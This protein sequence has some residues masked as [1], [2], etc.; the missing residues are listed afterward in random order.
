MLNQKITTQQFKYDP[1]NKKIMER[2]FH[3]L[4]FESLAT[5]I[6]APLFAYLMNKSII[7]MGILTIAIAT[8]AMSWNFIYNILFDKAQNKYQFSKTP[9][10]RVLHSLLFEF[11]L[12][13]ITIPLAAWWLSISLIS[14][15]FM[16]IGI[17]LFFLPYTIIYNWVYDT[18]RKF[19]WIY[20]Q[21]NRKSN[22]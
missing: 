18:F 21:K 6:C 14:A 8:I 12:I 15:F 17:L 5:L 3:A 11:G 13:F 4:L 22:K 19:L 20:F 1:T 9:L 7:D 2:I 10:I 16:E